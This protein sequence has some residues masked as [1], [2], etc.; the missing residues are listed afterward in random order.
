MIFSSEHKL[1]FAAYYEPSN[2]IWGWFE[3][4]SKREREVPSPPVPY[5]IYAFW[6][7]VG[8]TITIKRHSW[9]HRLDHTKSRKLQGKY[10]EID[11]QRLYELWPSFLDDMDQRMLFLS[12][13]DALDG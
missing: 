5:C 1:V 7:V 12:L 9:R 3:T 10:V 6:G 13:S 4:L 8:K 2:K 11:Q